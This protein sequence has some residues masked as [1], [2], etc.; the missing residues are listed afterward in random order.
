MKKSK[1][2]KK[3]ELKQKR[4]A[5]LGID[6]SGYGVVVWQCP[7]CRDFW[8]VTD[9]KSGPWALRCPNCGKPFAKWNK[10][11]E[12]KLSAELVKMEDNIKTWR[13]P[14]DDCKGEWNSYSVIDICPHCE[15]QL[16]S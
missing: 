2:S 6:A 9:L 14:H 15:G 1:K 5:R 3:P 4:F 11:L 7:Y 8:S 13:C 12:V 16:S 10:E